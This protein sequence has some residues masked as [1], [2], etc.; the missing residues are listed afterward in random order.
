ML[1]PTH[2]LFNLTL[3]QGQE[4]IA[5]IVADQLKPLY[6]AMR[7]SNAGKQTAKYL[8]TEQTLAYLHLTKPTL[9]KLRRENLVV[10]IQ[11]SDNR[12]LYDRD[13]LDTYL[14]SKTEKGKR[15]V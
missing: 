10:S 7:F 13:Q 8:T 9:N 5:T 4:L 1:K 6:E 3:E 2:F 12:V 11:C 14:Q 15:H